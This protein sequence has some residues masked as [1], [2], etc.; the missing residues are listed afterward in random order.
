ME[1]RV[2]FLL[3]V[4]QLATLSCST[5]VAAPGPIDGN[6]K[7][8]SI[9]CGGA[10]SIV[11]SSATIA[12][13]PDPAFVDIKNTSAVRTW[14]FP[15]A[16]GGGLTCVTRTGMN[17]IRYVNGHMLIDEAAVECDNADNCVG[18]PMCT[19]PAQPGLDY[20]YE[21]S[22]NTLAVTLAEPVRQGSVSLC[23]PSQDASQI[24]LVFTR[25]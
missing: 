16:L 6:W 13:S 17:S 5:E 12:S 11:M 20:P 9:R 22:G 1:Y 19:I 25:Q 4:V 21:V 14:T 2:I 8:S 7:L 24:D 23:D 15:S 10:D 18:N 3:I